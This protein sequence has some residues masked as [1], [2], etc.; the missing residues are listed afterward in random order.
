MK[1]NEYQNNN[2]I[3]TFILGA[4]ATDNFKTSTHNGRIL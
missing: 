3:N 2:I 4:T 1:V